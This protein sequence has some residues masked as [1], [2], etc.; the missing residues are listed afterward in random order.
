MAVAAVRVAI[1]GAGLMGR[2]HASAAA[3]AGGRVVAVVDPNQ[4][5]ADRLASEFRGACAFAEIAP[6]LDAVDVVHICTP[7]ETHV[8]IAHVAI[9][10]R[11]HVLVEK[12]IAA[13]AAETAD[14]LARAAEESVLLCPV[15]QF[16][17]QDG[18]RAALSS[19]AARSLQHVDITICSAGADGASAAA[20]DQIAAEIVP[21]AM[22]LLIRMRPAFAEVDW[23]ALH[24][25]FGEIRA[26][27]EA[28]RVT[29]TIVISMHGR[30]PVNRMRLIGEASTVH[31]DLF[32]GFAVTLS[33]SPSRRQKIAQPFLHAEAQFR[34]ATM[35]LARRAWRR[36]PAY[37]GLRALVQRFYE[38][39]LGS[40]IAAIPPEETLRTARACDRVVAALSLQPD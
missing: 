21:H 29:A 15:H 10:A 30:P 17:F 3:R 26:L 33:G 1:V 19:P 6:S 2:W 32:H 7:A 28:D 5:R 39:V 34:A 13:T 27:A 20:A 9:G 16:L 22:S 4:A 37:P 12:P 18:V 14:L 40:A 8:P 24:P 36:E 38:E 25:R 31:V 23:A 35:N 11:R